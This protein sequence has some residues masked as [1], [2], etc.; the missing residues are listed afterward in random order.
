M[1]SLPADALTLSNSLRRL[2]FLRLAIANDSGWS[3]T[4]RNCSRGFQWGG[5]GVVRLCQGMPLATHFSRRTACGVLA[6]W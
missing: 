3:I 2:Y 6:S 5:G 4:E 1:T